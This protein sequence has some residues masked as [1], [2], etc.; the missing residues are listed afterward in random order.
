MAERLMKGRRETGTCGKRESAYVELKGRSVNQE[1]RF[2]GWSL[3]KEGREG[4]A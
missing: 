3:Q 1:K 2:L 4:S